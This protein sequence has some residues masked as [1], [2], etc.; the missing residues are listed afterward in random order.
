MKRGGWFREH[1]SSFAAPSLHTPPRPATSSQ[2][3]RQCE[4]ESRDT[5]E[6]CDLRTDAARPSWLSVAGVNRGCCCAPQLP[7]CSP[8]AAAL[9]PPALC[10]PGSPARLRSPYFSEHGAGFQGHQHGCAIGSPQHLHLSRLD[11][12]HLAADLSLRGG[13]VLR[14]SAQGQ[15]D[16]ED[17]LTCALPETPRA[18]APAPS[19]QSA[20]PWWCPLP[21]SFTSACPRLPQCSR[22]FPR[23][24][25]FRAAAREVRLRTRPSAA[26]AGFALASPPDA[27]VMGQAWLSLHCAAWPRH[28]A[29]RGEGTRA[30]PHLLTNVVVR[31]V[32]H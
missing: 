13:R 6:G 32:D 27:S 23:L 8:R 1:R 29:G 17:A 28:Q 10:P 21:S 3:R 22:L 19:P 31:E 7:P 30:S 25:L 5:E 16:S 9:C 15:G 11:D 18:I 24:L 20:L 26:E 2:G 12:V 4:D 14:G